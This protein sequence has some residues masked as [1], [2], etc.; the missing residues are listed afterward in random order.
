MVESS[1][2]SFRLRLVVLCDSPAHS[3]KPLSIEFLPFLV[4]VELNYEINLAGDQKTRLPEER[5]FG[6]PLALSAFDLP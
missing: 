4:R 3:P 2:A 6:R 5:R 1:P